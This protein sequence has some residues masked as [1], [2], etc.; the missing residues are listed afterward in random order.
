[1]SQS[2]ESCALC[3]TR[4]RSIEYELPIGTI[5]AC[6]RCGL[7]SLVDSETSELV[8]CSY[9]AGYYHAAAGN[10][11]VGYTD[12]FGSE[13]TSRDSFARSL[14]V[15]LTTRFP[16]ARKTLDIGC[17]GGYLVRALADR[18]LDARG[19]D[20][21]AFAVAHGVEGTAGRLV[22]GTMSVMA[23]VAPFDIVTMMDVI[24]HL[25]DPVSA[26]RGAFSFLREGGSLVVLTPRYGG[27]LLQRQGT[28][29]VHFNSDHMYYFTE[30]TL[31]A[32]LRKAT[33]SDVATQDVLSTLM[34]WHVAVPADVQ[35]KYTADRDSIIAVVTRELDVLRG[36][37]LLQF[38]NHLL[39]VLSATTI[40]N[41]QDIR[42]VDDDEVF[43][44]DR[45]H[46]PASV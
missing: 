29:Y 21:S 4:K 31:S 10:A 9:D 11:S 14:A 8:T 33:G 44:A 2:Y 22:E 20:T 6:E 45:R 39:D 23:D 46:E 26:I 41:Q 36:A 42:R 28:E 37:G 19:V 7:V 12:Y 17:G 25:P 30:Q 13:A 43:D 38:V 27:A 18:G 5:V 40:T 3:D 24:E 32:V 35:H 1:M 15:G 16:A 34:D